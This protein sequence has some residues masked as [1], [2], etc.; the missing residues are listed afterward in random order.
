MT[1]L[2]D[3]AKLLAEVRALRAR[4]ARTVCNSI[5]LR[6]QLEQDIQSLHAAIQDSYLVRGKEQI[7]GSKHR[8]RV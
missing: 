1:T 8:P 7:R 2:A 4:A 5:L 6:L 3:T